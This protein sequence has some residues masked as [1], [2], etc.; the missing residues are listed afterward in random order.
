MSLSWSL[1]LGVAEGGPHLV[2]VEQSGRAPLPGSL[3]RLIS[4]LASC[5]HCFFFLIPALLSLISCLCLQCGAWGALIPL[6][7][8][9]AAAAFVQHHLLLGTLFSSPPFMPAS[10][11]PLLLPLPHPHPCATLNPS[12]C[13][14][15]LGRQAP[16][17]LPPPRPPPPPSSIGSP[18]RLRSCSILPICGQDVAQMNPRAPAWGPGAP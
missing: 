11:K 12:I 13:V 15:E 4:H 16:W 14:T 3:P 2:S 8:L 18:N 6:P 5:L 7:I 10:P 9:W 17:P 1:K